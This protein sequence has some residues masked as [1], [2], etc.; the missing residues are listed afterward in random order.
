MSLEDFGVVVCQLVRAESAER[1]P[2]VIRELE[3]RFNVVFNGRHAP[4]R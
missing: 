1:E 2:G 3:T 4:R